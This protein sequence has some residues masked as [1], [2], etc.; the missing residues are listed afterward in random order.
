VIKLSVLS[1]VVATLALVLSGYTGGPVDGGGTVS[2][3]VR[4]QG[5]APRL[6][7]H[8]IT[9]SANVCGNTAPNETVVTG[10]GGALANA[11]VW[12]DN[13]QQGAPVR[14]RNI[15][16][17]QQNCR[18]V[19]HVAATTRGSQLTVTSS[20][21]TL[22][23]VHA[24]RGNSTA[25]NLATP[26][27]GMRVNRPLSQSGLLRFQCDAGHTW[28]SAFVHVF[29]HPYFAVTG[30]NGSFSLPDVPPGTYTLK[31]WHERLGTQTQ[32]IEV[33]AGGTVTQDFRLSA[34]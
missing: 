30:R 34:R 21:D 32:S 2:G 18:Y 19:P 5:A 6:P 25:F 27:K 14:R 33:S 10:S 16:L 13:I 22:H 11:V 3:T 24:F 31:V 28:M 9:K 23:N 1:G 4:L 20:D 17:D 8:N 12:I 15:T 29:D 26:V 7:A